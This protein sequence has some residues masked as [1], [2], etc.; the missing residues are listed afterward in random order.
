MPASETAVP[1]VLPIPKA[2]AMS[3]TARRVGGDVG[4]AGDPSLAHASV[5]AAAT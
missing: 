3:A 2:A 5:R 4:E 1:A